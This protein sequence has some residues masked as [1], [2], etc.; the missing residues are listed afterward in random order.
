MT[1][2][3]SFTVKRFG[4]ISFSATI[5]ILAITIIFLFYVS[6]SESHA[7]TFFEKT[8]VIV[9]AVFAWPTWVTAFIFHRD[10]PVIFW[11]LSIVL[12]GLFW[13]G[14]IEIFFLSE[15]IYPPKT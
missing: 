6:D 7:Y 13:A 4:V 1:G 3:L 9:W 8:V 2:K 12:A 15:K 5:V 14:I 10:P 11:L